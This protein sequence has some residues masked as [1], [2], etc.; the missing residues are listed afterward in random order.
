[1]KAASEISFIIFEAAIFIYTKKYKF[2][3]GNIM[4]L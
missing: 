3:E 2:K 1:M 4:F